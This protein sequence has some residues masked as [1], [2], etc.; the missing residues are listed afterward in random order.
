MVLPGKQKLD[1][2]LVHQCLYFGVQMFNGLVEFGEG[3][4]D[5]LSGVGLMG[6]A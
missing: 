1:L 2:V 6:G 5:L 4:A 3:V